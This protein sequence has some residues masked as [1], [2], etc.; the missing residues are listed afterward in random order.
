[1]HYFVLNRSHYI[2]QFLCC[3][4][5]HSQFFCLI[6][7]CM[8]VLSSFAFLPFKLNLHN[9]V[10]HTCTVQLRVRVIEGR[11]LQ[12]NNISPVCRVSVRR[13]VNQTEVCPS[14][15]SP[16]WN[17]SFVFSL[18]VSL[19]EI[20]DDILMFEVCNYSTVT[21]M[22]YDLPSSVPNTWPAC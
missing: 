14:T 21:V 17:R 9:T 8:T 5:Q 22:F 4:I 12:G 6:F 18:H 16:V 2:L 20:V 11:Q 1:M 19:A 3:V 10:W 13:Q 7:N 15:N